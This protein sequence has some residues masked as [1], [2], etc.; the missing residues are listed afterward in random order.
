MTR[1]IYIDVDVKVSG[2]DLLDMFREVDYNGEPEHE[3]VRLEI[4]E[5]GE[6]HFVDDNCSEDDDTVYTQTYERSEWLEDP[7][8]EV[9]M[10]YW[11]HAL[12]EF[13]HGNPIEIDTERY[14][15]E[16]E[17]GEEEYVVKH[18]RFWIEFC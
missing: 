16:S 5:D 12:N 9:I 18:T 15:E 2:Q 4:N 6:S 11:I 14:T 13:Y 17:D 8:E 7:D 3:V 1:D 10:E